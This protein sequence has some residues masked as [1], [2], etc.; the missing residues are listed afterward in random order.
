MTSFDINKIYNK[1]NNTLPFLNKREIFPP[2]SNTSNLSKDIILFNE[3]SKQKNILDNNEENNI[4]NEKNIIIPSN[5]NGIISHKSENKNIDRN[6][7]EIFLNE[8]YC[9]LIN[10]TEKYDEHKIND[11]V[12]LPN[13]P[14]FLNDKK[15]IIYKNQINKNEVNINDISS[16]SI[17]NNL[18]LFNSNYWNYLNNNFLIPNP[19]LQFPIS[20]YFKQSLLFNSLDNKLNDY[21]LN[22]KGNG[23]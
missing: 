14:Q 3:I 17:I 8:K 18:H 1:S 6:N 16:K 15:E 13:F 22:L 9:N 19:L 20:S 11:M 5:Y 12:D 4:I 10:K 7:N 21:P 23:F 2:I